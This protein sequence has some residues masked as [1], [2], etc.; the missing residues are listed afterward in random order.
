MLIKFLKKLFTEVLLDLYF[1]HVRGVFSPF[2][3]KI[4][5]LNNTKLHN[6]PGGKAKIH[7]LLSVT[8]EP[9]RFPQNHTPAERTPPRQHSAPLQTPPARHTS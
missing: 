2:T 4:K 9:V 6:Y 5:R 8:P 7:T 1:K 3:D